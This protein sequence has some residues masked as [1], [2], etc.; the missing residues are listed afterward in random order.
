[1]LVIERQSSTVIIVMNGGWNKS[2]LY[3]VKHATWK[4]IYILV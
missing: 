4:N 1:M 3:F 2:R